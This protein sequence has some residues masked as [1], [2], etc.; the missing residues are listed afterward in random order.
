MKQ[1]IE[2]ANIFHQLHNA[3]TPLILVNIWDAGSAKAIQQSGA[4]AI[5][6]SSWSVA[7]ANGYEDGENIPFFTILNNI[8]RITNAVNL[9]VTIDIEAGYSSSPQG[10]KAVI[11]EIINAG[12]VGINL[13]DQIINGSELYSINEQCSR[14]AAAREAAEENSMPLFI[15]ARTDM[16]L[17]I[18][19]Q[20]HT[21]SHLSQAIE[22]AIAYKKT[23]A[24]GFFVPGL[25]DINLIQKLCEIS[26][27]PVNI[28]I[29]PDMPAIN[30]LTKLGVARISYG[31]SPYNIVMQGL[32][33]FANNALGDLA[34]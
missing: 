25:K 27:L 20:D 3:K 13:E 6:T 1:Q 26:P 16:F 10:I 2:K 7:A 21:E 34:C 29:L 23:R 8:N 14:I 28:M 5:A 24:N 22:R 19:P 11:K 4:K 15:N 30:E 17:K 9:P 31:P 12:I 18:N 32:Q 33:A